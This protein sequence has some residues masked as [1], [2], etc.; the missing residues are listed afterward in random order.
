MISLII[1][2]SVSAV[3]FVFASTFWDAKELLKN[4]AIVIASVA[5]ISYTSAFLMSKQ[6]PS[7]IFIPIIF[8]IIFLLFYINK[9]L[10]E[11][12]LSIK[13]NQQRY[14]EEVNSDMIYKFYENRKKIIC[15]FLSVVLTN[16]ISC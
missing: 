10:K 4:S 9:S 8:L 6:S 3:C 1:L 12:S 16:I 2:L 13:A 14:F 11:N 15:Y 5:C 7:A